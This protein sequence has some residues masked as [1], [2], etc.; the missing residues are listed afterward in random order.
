MATVYFGTNRK[1]TGPLSFGAA[2]GPP[3]R[4]GLICAEAT[5]DG[6]TL[7][8]ADSGRITA[9]AHETATGFAPATRETILAS[10]KNLLVFI[11]GFANAFENA[12]S[13]AG[14][15]R[16]W[17]ASSTVPGADMT[18]IAF[19]WPSSGAVIA[20]P[21]HFLD[22]AYRE[23][24][25]QAGGSG[26]HLAWFFD[27]IKSLRDEAKRRNPQ[28]RV[29]LLSHSMGNY[30]LAAG[31]QSWFLTRNATPIFDHAVLAAADEFD[32]S[33]ELPP[34]VRLSRLPDLAAGISV[35]Y[36]LRDVA[37]YL[38][39]AVNLTERLGFDGPA[40]K[41]NPTLYP[42]NR[43]R[44]VNCTDLNDYNFAVPPDSSHQYYRR[45]PK[46]R[47][48]IARALSGQPV[49]PGESTLV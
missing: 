48:D 6:L 4:T 8:D 33:F 37:M 30:A 31:V 17:F 10:G 35:Y 29:V 38:S 41:S 43:F 36:S 24:Q 45:S 20:C 49:T 42:P 21:P 26:P 47:D 32:K 15:N 19:S 3:D 16:E 46:A 28:R 25:A 23:D 18:V 14:Y 39:Q 2:M 34:G 13:R 5:V 22:A 44:S 7:A 1:Q 40:H 27:E 11:H 9:I 12:I